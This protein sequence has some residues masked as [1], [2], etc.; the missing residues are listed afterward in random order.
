M[1]LVAPKVKSVLANAETTIFTGSGLIYGIVHSG[2]S[3]NNVAFLDVDD[4]VILITSTQ[5]F[6]VAEIAT[7]FMLENGLKVPNKSAVGTRIT[8]YYD[9]N[10]SA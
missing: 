2:N 4:N 10:V 7:P 5:S 9:D 1:R 8:V 3:S 6:T